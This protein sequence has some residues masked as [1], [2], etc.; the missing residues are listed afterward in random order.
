MMNRA[1]LISKPL[2]SDSV[3]GTFVSDD[4]RPG[5]SGSQF[6]LNTKQGEVSRS[7]TISM[8]IDEVLLD[9]QESCIL[10][11]DV[12]GLDFEIL[13]GA[14]TSLASQQIYS[15]LIEAPEKIQKDVELFLYKFSLVPDPNFNDIDLHSDS[16]RK[17][18]NSL[19]RNRVYTLKRFL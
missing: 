19:E 11:I 18:N 14:K 3:S 17:R 2:F 13:K 16:R 7:E 10:K 1:F 12:D 4:L 15:V 5:S 6:A 8:T 9:S